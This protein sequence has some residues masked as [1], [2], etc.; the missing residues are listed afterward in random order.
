MSG[1][2]FVAVAL[3][4]VLGSLVGAR[5]E[6]DNVHHVPLTM[7]QRSHDE[8]IAF[9]ET[10][11]SAHAA[12]AAGSPE[13]SAIMLGNFKDT[14]FMGKVGVGTPPQFFS[15]IFDTGSANFWIP[16]KECESIGC[17]SHTRFDK[18][19]SSSFISDGRPMH[20]K[21]GSGAV[22]GVLGVD[23]VVFGKARC[24]KQTL[25]F[26]QK[27]MGRAFVM[28][29]FAGILGL[30]FQSI[31]VNH[32]LPVFDS[33]MSQKRLKHNVFSFY[34]SNKP[35]KMGGAIVVG[36]VD[37]RLY[38]GEFRFVELSSDTYWQV[39][40]KDI[41]INGESQGFCGT[42]SC[43]VAVDTGT[44]LITGP[45]EDISTLMNSVRS[46]RDCSNHDQLPKITFVMANGEKFDLDPIDY[47]FAYQSTYM[48]QCV[49]GVM[50]L[51]V[52]APRG[53]IWILGDV[54]IRRYYTQFD[55][56]N[57]RVGFAEALHTTEKET[58][59]LVEKDS[60]D[61]GATMANL[62]EHTF[63]DQSEE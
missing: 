11:H 22:D 37:K 5:T 27:E 52:P 7:H 42:E 34:L 57:R 6:E 54:F 32:V 3:L 23:D 59:Q 41:L 49:T 30:A 9:I 36:G 1:K 53:P 8:H 35:G 61:Q 45:S 46:D 56:D 40:M 24:K 14:Q 60:A 17:R 4:V 47:V 15:V 50:P 16:S 55:R 43:K 58:L 10:M 13:T 18:E 44:S 28:G 21:Y 29:H 39:A 25:G 26:I 38:K 62:Q 2:T 51:D 20:I 33:L 31:A 63:F 12:H 19:K 48:K